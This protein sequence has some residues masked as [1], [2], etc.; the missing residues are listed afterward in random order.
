MASCAKRSACFL[1]D[2]NLIVRE[3]VR[4][5]L[6]LEAD[7]EVVGVAARLRRAGRGRRRRPRRRC[8]SPTSGCRR[9]SSARASTRPRS[10]ASATPAPASSCSRSTT[11]PSTRSRCS[12]DGAAGYAYLLKDRVAEG[13]QLARAVREVATG[14]I[15]ARP[16][17]RRGAGPPGRRRR[18]ADQRRGGAAPAGRRGHADQGDRRCAADDAR[19]G[20]RRGRGAVPSSWPRACRRGE[21][22]RAAAAA[23]AAPG[24]RRPRGAGRD[25][26]SRLLPSGLAEK[27]RSERPARSARPRRSSSPC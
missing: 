13:D 12:A 17:D 24:D 3:G 5:L 11:T 10:C 22:R 2:D 14:G 9:P 21:R 8:S 1:A 23:A 16:D 19:G 20:R 25:A 6:A 26:V 18:R 4:A 27:V 7:L 15:G